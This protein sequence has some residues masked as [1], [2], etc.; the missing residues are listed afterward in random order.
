MTDEQPQILGKARGALGG[1]E[2]RDGYQKIRINLVGLAQVL[3]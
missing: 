1:E 3:C 2:L